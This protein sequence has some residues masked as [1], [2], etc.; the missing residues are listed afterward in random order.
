MLFVSRCS[1]RAVLL[2]VLLA[3]LPM[4][5]LSHFLMLP[6]SRCPLHSLSCS[7]SHPLSCCAV[8]RP[9]H[10]FLPLPLTPPFSHFLHSPSH[11]VPRAPSRVVALEFPLAPSL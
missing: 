10:I 1:P 6:L 5:S 11:A 2:A 3:V 8:Y 9:S 4:L 7:L